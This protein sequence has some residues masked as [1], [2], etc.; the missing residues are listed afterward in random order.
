MSEPMAATAIVLAGGRASRFGSD[1]LTADVGGEPLLLRA[2]R[3]VADVCEDVLVVGPPTGLSVEVPALTPVVLDATPFEG[4]LV[5]LARAAPVASQSRLLLVGGDMPELQAPLLRRLLA[6][7]EARE[8]AC[9]VDGGV[10]RPLPVGLARQAAAEHARAL[11][12]AGER[13]LR[14]LLEALDLERVLE[15]EWRA[16]DPDARSFRD[17]DRPADLKDVRVGLDR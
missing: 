6:W 10:D 3:A 7:P 5:A 13:S 17:V 14:A 2:I 16:L 8:G 4:P 11:V 12:D 15:P 1:K 9:L